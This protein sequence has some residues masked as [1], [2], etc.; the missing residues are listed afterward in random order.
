MR[1]ECDYLL[2][3]VAVLA[4]VCGCS[5]SPR[6]LDP[7]ANPDSDTTSIDAP[8]G[9]IVR[10]IEVVDGKVEGGPHVDFPV[11]ISLL[12]NELKTVDAG[13]KV[14]NASGFDIGFFGDSG[15]SQ[16]LAYE[17]ERYDGAAGE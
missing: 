3:R 6:P 7:G 2:V 9:A 12:D 14:A 4:C 11:L 10:A 1:R 16:R 15:I 17:V 13:G 5:F 8:D